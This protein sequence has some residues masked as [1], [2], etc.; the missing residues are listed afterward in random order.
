MINPRAVIYNEE[1]LTIGDNVRI[2]DFCILSCGAGLII[3][4]NVHIAAYTII[5]ASSAKVIIE[6]HVGISAHCAFYSGSDDYNG[7]GMLAW[8]PAVPDKFKN[9][10]KGDIIIGRHTLIGHSVTVMPGVK[11]GEGVAIGARSFVSKDCDPW[12]IYAGIPAKKIK[13]RKRDLLELEK[14]WQKES[15]R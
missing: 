15:T 5:V 1:N 4:S 9:V 2:D 13:D 8:N 7:G 3:G 12:S 14:Q 6:D 11:M 10:T